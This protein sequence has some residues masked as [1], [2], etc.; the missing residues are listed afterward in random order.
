MVFVLQV[1]KK[2]LA[3]TESQEGYHGNNWLLQ[4]MNIVE[5]TWSH[6]VL[7]QLPLQDMKINHWGGGGGS[8]LGLTAKQPRGKRV[9]NL[10]HDKWYGSN[11]PPL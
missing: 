11:L 8:A 7:K 2:Q 10:T 3:A 5:T 4:V 6:N 1:M 9:T